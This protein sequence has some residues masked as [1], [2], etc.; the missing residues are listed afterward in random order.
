MSPF[1]DH[2]NKVNIEIRWGTQVNSPY[3][4]KVRYTAAQCIQYSLCEDS[5]EG[6]M[7]KLKLQYSGHL[8]WKVDL[9]EKTLMLGKIKG[10]RRRRQQRIRWLA[11]ITN[12]MGMNLSELQ[13]TVKD[14]EAWHA[15]VHGVAE[16]GATQ[17]LNIV[18]IKTIFT[19]W[20]K[21]TVALCLKIIYRP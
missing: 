20:F 11:N 2:C 13:E 14:R 5:T 16:A 4:N 6:L 10:K 21:C 19:L 17:Q 8:M 9:L 3:G 7:L 1:P 18:N 15:I 12:S